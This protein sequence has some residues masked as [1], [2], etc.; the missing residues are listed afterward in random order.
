MICPFFI[1]FSGSL[2]HCPR[3][4]CREESG[5]AR[6]RPL[7]P[8]TSRWPSQ[9]HM[10]CWRPQQIC[11]KH[12]QE[13]VG[14]GFFLFQRL[15]W[16]FLFFKSGTPLIVWQP[17]STKLLTGRHVLQVGKSILQHN[18][19]SPNQMISRW[20][21]MIYFAY[22]WY[23]FMKILTDLVLTLDNFSHILPWTWTAWDRWDQVFWELGRKLEIH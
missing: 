3:T 15:G 13:E 12:K 8:P 17:V 19:I 4:T 5:C 11:L 1:V 23:T 16:S 14:S 10:R 2:S 7:K 21:L 6:L 18:Q 9:L 22:E 20:Y